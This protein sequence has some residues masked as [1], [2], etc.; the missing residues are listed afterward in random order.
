[1]IFQTAMDGAY[2]DIAFRAVHNST[3]GTSTVSI[4][5]GSPLILETATASTGGNFV[6]LALTSTS[7]INNLYVGN[8]NATMASDSVGLAQCYGVDTDALTA[9]AGAV[10]GAQLIPNVGTLITVGAS[11]A[12]NAGVQGGGSGALTVY[13]APTGAT[14][15]ASLVFV[16]AM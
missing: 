5:I 4:L 12:G 6:M 15:V 13:V 3:T 9:T 1:M 7:I 8:A 16:R 11:T 10:V 2:S 14:N